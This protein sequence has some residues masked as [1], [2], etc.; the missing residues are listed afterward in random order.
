MSFETVYGVDFSAHGSEAGYR[1]WVTEAEPDAEELRV[2]ASQ[3]ATD[4]LDGDPKS[5]EETLPALVEFLAARED[6]VV[7]LDFP[8]SLPYSVVDAYF[9]SDDWTDFV[10]EFAA[11]WTS[12]S[13]MFHAVHDDES[14]DGDA[15]R[16][17]DE[18]RRGQPPTGWRIKTQTYYGISD[19][20]SPL[21]HEHGARVAPF[22][23][24]GSGVAL[25]ETYPAGLFD[26]LGLHREGYKDVPEASR[27]RRAANLRGLQREGLSVSEDVGCLATHNDDALDSLAAAFAA[28]D[29]LDAF[30]TSEGSDDIEGRIYA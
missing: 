18:Q 23:T 16:E 8:F 19:V 7:G 2:V 24:A 15:L 4:A 13:E 28:W 6:A 21:V 20:L 26:R 9:A 1:T 5:R 29:N 14:I 27:E 25:M 12:P 10:F 30:S 11:D 17:T 3:C 22:A